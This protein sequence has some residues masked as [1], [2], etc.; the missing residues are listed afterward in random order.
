MLARPALPPE[1]LPSVRPVGDNDSV[2]TFLAVSVPLPLLERKDR[3]GW[4]EKVAAWKKKYP[5]GYDRKSTNIKPQYVIEQIC[6]LTG[7]DA[8][9]TT[10]V[11]QHQMWTSQFY[12]FKR[13]RV[14]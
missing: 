2:P 3:A 6:E 5:L 9:I 8:I 7:G 13:P 14:C 11:G 12:K 10:G 1:P 4:L